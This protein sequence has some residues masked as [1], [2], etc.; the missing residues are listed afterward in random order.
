MTSLSFRAIHSSHYA[1]Y[2]EADTH[3]HIYIYPL[4]RTIVSYRTLTTSNINMSSNNFDNFDTKFE[5]NTASVLASQ[6]PPAHHTHHSSDAIRPAADYSTDITND[7]SAWEGNNKRQFGAGTDDRAVMAGGQR[8]GAPTLPSSTSYGEGD[9]DVYRQTQ[10]VDDGRNAFHEE[11][12]MNVMP[13][14]AGKLLHLGYCSHSLTPFRH[15]RSCDRWP[16]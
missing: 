5:Q 8:A 14:G 16:R 9:S 6:P 12:P 11:R 10:P 15:R 2:V 1:T 13:T 7:A 3:T 4:F